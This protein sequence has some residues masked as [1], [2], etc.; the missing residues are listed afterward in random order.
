MRIRSIA[1]IVLALALLFAVGG[2]CQESQLPA[3]PLKTPLVYRN[4]KDSFCL[5]LPV[6]WA[7]FKVLAVR[8]KGEWKWRKQIG[9]QKRH[10]ESA[11]DEEEAISGHSNPGV[12]FCA[13]ARD[14]EQ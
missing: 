10:P 8:W 13:V 2:V 7:G 6:D 1:K 5:A 14:R 3:K 9:T 4:T 12:H 11:M